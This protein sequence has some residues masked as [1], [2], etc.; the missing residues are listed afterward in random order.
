MPPLAVQLNA[1]LPLAEW[2][3]PTTVE[4]SADT[5]KARLE[6]ALKRGGF[7]GSG[8]YSRHRWFFRRVEQTEPWYYR[9]PDA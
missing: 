4:P 1:S 5:P 9:P 8:A 3:P 2:P 6:E 7:T